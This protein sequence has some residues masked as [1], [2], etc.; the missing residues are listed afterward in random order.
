MHMHE[1]Y[2]PED[3]PVRHLTVLCSELI[4]P[5]IGTSDG[6]SP[7]FLLPSLNDYE[8]GFSQVDDTS[9]QLFVL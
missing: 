8:S 6:S 9:Q 5:S 7:H 3:G 2:D 1:S 4:P